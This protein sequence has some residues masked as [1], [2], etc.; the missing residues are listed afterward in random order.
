MNTSS[1]D[2]IADTINAAMQKAGP[3]AEQGWEILVDGYRVTG[4]LELASALVL[5][6]TS[7]LLVHIGRGMHIAAQRKDIT[8]RTFT[9][10][11]GPGCLVL[12]GF[13]LF[14]VALH[15]LYAGAYYVL[16]PEHAA[17]LELLG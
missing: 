10:D 2:Q 13:V 17:V 4:Y 6:L 8:D 16:A 14:F 15:A 5:L 9:E 1:I 3:L 7:A 12:V 11:M